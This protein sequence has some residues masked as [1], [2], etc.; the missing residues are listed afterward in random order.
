MANLMLYSD[1]PTFRR[2]APT[3]GGIWNV[4]VKE[5]KA[6]KTLEDM[7]REI[8]KHQFLDQL[9][10][11]CHGFP[12]GMELED[13][14]H[15]MLSDKAVADA[16]AKV[17][18]QV[19][20]IRFEGCWV[21]NRPVH[22]RNFGR[23]LRAIDVSGYTWEHVDCEVTATIPRGATPAEIESLLGKYWRWLSPFPPESIPRLASLARNHDVKKA[24]WIE[25]YK[26]A[27]DGDNPPPPW[28]LSRQGKDLILRPHGYKV[29]SEADK[30]VIQA[31]DI[32]SNED[33]DDDEEPSPPFEYV[34]VE[35]HLGGRVLDI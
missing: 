6:F 5:Q 15:Y 31:K 3:V 22:M 9:V 13:G 16:L 17:K 34:V 12:G 25:W 28:D 35:L 23:L 19:D 29:R 24:L 14:R 30:H 4:G 7:A 18:T 1:N 33:E 2:Y 8:G 32:K 20:H 26:Y 27:D 11:F 21:G 10:I